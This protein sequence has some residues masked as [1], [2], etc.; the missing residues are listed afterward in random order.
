MVSLKSQKSILFL[1]PSFEFDYVITDL[2]ITAKC[3]SKHHY[4]LAFIFIFFERA[5]LL[6]LLPR[7]KRD[8]IWYKTRTSS[9]KEAIHWL[10]AISFLLFWS[11][12]WGLLW[13][14]QTL[15]TQDISASSDWCRSVKT[16]LQQC[17]SVWET[18]RNWCQTVSTFIRHTFVVI[19]Q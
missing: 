13:G 15:R 19:P 14:V 7:D 9:C 16:F 8:E 3:K 10:C 5:W 12:R 17:R 2:Q 18:V 1:Y 4:K 6:L 11:L